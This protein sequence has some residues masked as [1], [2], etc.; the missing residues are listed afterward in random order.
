MSAFN[1]IESF[2]LLSLGITFVLIVLLVYHFKQRLSS[3]EQKCDTMF[4]IVQNLVKELKIV[5]NACQGQ[6]LSVG[7]ASC[8]IPPFAAFQNATHHWD[9]GDDEDESEDENEDNS[10]D[11]NEDNSDDDKSVK[12]INMELGNKI[13]MIETNSESESESET[14]IELNVNSD[15][16]II[17]K[18]DDIPMVD[19]KKT[20]VVELK[21]IVTSKG[22]TANAYKLTKPELLDL[23]EK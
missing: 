13:E 16:P 17:H 22:L 12:I 20:S 5:K 9:E 14:V 8:M 23:L 1:F 6:S 11:E 18:I 10:E 2:F 15:V 7:P 3:M 21:R 19:Y 4:D